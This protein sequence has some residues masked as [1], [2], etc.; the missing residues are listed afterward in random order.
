M[1]FFYALSK[2]SS[3]LCIIVLLIL[4]SPLLI[5][6]IKLSIVSMITSRSQV[7]TTLAVLASSFKRAISQNISQAHSSAIW[8]PF[9]RILTLHDFM[10][11]HS[12]FDAS[13]STRIISPSTNFLSSQF[14]IILSTVSLSIPWKILSE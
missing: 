8:V 14:L 5:I 4:F 10:M 7:T 6:S 2:F 3:I 1:L 11:Y 13:H 12:P 9:I